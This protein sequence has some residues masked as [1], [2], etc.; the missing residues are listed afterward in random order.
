MITVKSAKFVKS[1]VDASGFADFSM[2]EIAVVGRSNVGKSSFINMLAGNS[3]L[4]KTSSTPGR[5]RLVNYFEMQ[6]ADS[7]AKSKTMPLMLVDLPGYGYAKASA[8][9]QNRWK[10]MIETYFDGAQN[11]KCVMLL[12][13]IRH[14]PT[15]KDLQMF[16]YLFRYNISTTIIATKADKLSKNEIR[17][18]VTAIA[19]AFKVGIGNILVTSSEK[20]LG[21]EV[22]LER[23]AQFAKGA[24]NEDLGD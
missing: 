8:S 19:G 22:V 2:P 5:T 7:T 11:L 1:A 13:D 18:S 21:K 10:D 20:K 15:I 6:L 17:K 4:A 24:D 9:E 23:M 12:V 14:E 3:K 16:D